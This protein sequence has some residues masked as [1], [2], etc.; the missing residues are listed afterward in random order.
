MAEASGPSGELIRDGDLSIRRMRDE[1]SEFELLL[2]WRAEPHV[3]EWWDTDDPPLTYERAVAEYLEDLEPRGNTIPCI[4]EVSG[5]PAGY[6]QFY[7]WAAFAGEAKQMGMPA[8]EGAWGLDILIGDPSLIGKGVGSRAVD[9]VCRY[10]LDTRQAHSVALCT[11]IRNTRAQRAYEKAG[12]VKVRRVLDTDTR[13][14]ARIPSWL[15][16]RDLAGPQ[17]G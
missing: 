2:A 13:D 15:L 6:V 11:A 9:L 4:I 1:P 7:A 5:R 8:D 3:S 17:R 10:L 14:G 16:V 12:F